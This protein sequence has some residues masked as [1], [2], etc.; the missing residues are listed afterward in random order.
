MS[1]AYN[2]TGSSTQYSATTLCSDLTLSAATTS[3]KVLV[4]VGTTTANST[5][6]HAF[7]SPYPVSA[8][9]TFSLPNGPSINYTITLASGGITGIST[10]IC[11]S[12]T[13]FNAS[14]Q[15]YTINTA[16]SSVDFTTTTNS[17]SVTVLYSVNGIQSPSGN[18]ALNA[19]AA[20]NVSITAS[21]S[22]VSCSP[23]Y[24]PYVYT[25]NQVQLALSSLSTSAGS[26]AP[27][28][29]PSVFQYAL[30]TQQTTLTLTLG[31]PSVPGA[32]CTAWYN[33]ALVPCSASISLKGI[34]DND[35]LVVG[36]SFSTDS[37][38]IY[39]NYTITFT[40]SCTLVLS[41]GEPTYPNT[42]SSGVCLI[43]SKTFTLA[44]NASATSGSCQPS[45]IQYLI[46][47]EWVNCASTNCNLVNGANYY[48]VQSVD[49]KQSPIT[50][51]NVS[52]SECI[53]WDCADS[54]TYA[55]LQYTR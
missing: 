11:S 40:T 8:P 9:V 48:R 54:V 36:L 14:I 26:F 21:E 12:T 50:Y 29:D 16:A 27:D 49:P 31:L 37:P 22:G 1:P 15:A 33:G 3:K 4:T 45:S 47:N 34:A 20:T 32:Q 53:V 43:Q 55:H 19:G 38:A 23:P 28:F 46:D 44:L 5:A 6:S 30:E 10:S 24:T 13:P 39:T 25:I 35:V 18:I 52:N 41:L 51:L 7:D 42:C 2:S 17:S